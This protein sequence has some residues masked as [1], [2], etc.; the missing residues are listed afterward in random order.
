ME[1]KGRYIILDRELN[2]LDIFALDF[3]EILKK[4][5]LY[6]VISGYISIL[7]GRTRA[8][9]DIDVYINFLSKE[10]FLQLYN[11]LD[12]QGFWCLNVENADEVYSYL[13]DGLAVR[14]S[15]KGNSIPNFE[16]K[17]IRRFY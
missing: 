5:T 6:V 15:R 16:V 1:L 11:E 7:L 3:L 17:F 4:H 13:Y 10:V 12:M 14:F 8:T 9:E 2:E